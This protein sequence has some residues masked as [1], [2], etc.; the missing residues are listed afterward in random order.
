MY[1][2]LLLMLSILCISGMAVAQNVMTPTDGDYIYNTGA[3]AGSLTNPTAIDGIIQKWVHDPTQKPGRIPWTQSDFKSY[4][5]NNISFRLRF[6]NNYDPLQKYPLIVF[7]HGAGEAALISNSHNTSLISRENQDQLYWG[8]KLFRDTIN[9]PGSFNGFLLFPQ[10]LAGPNNVGTQWDQNT[11]D[12]VNNIL[13]TLEKYNGL[14]P[15]RVIAMGLSAG[16]LGCVKYAA[17]FP[18]RIAS[19]VTAGP[20]QLTDVLADIDGF[21][22]VPIYATIGGTDVNPYPITVITVRDQFAGKGGDFFLGFYPTLNHDTWETQWQQKN[23]YNRLLLTAYWNKASKAQP[24]VY[25]QASEFCSGQ[26]ISAKMGITAGFFAYEW[27]RDG[28]S[29][30]VTIPG[31][32]ANTY[33]ATQTGLYR[34]HFKRT[35]AY[36]WSDWTPNPVAITTKACAVTDTAFAEHFENSPVNNY[37]TFSGSGSGNSPYY[38]N[39][40][41][42]QNGFFVNGSEVFTQD[43][44]GRQGGKFMF[45]WTRNTNCAY[46]AGD[47][48]WRTYFPADVTPNTDYTLNFYMANQGTSMGAT[49]T[50]TVTAL[51]PKINN[52]ALS[53]VGVS[54]NG[55]GHL[56]WKKYSFNWNSGGNTSAEIAITNNVATGTGND[57]VLDEISLVKS[58]LVPMP[59]GALKNVDLW[60]KGSS[61]AS[62]DGGPVALWP[63]NDIN[64]NSLTQTLASSQPLYQ[65][66]GTDNIN[67][68]PVTAFLPQ[69]NKYMTVPGGFD[70]TAATTHTA[71]YAYM[72]LRTLATDQNATYLREGPTGNKLVM[73]QSTATVMKWNGGED[74]SNIIQ[75]PSGSIDLK[76]TIWS[77]SKNTVATPSGN[78]RDIRKNGLVLASSNTATTWNGSNNT[79]YLS[80]FQNTTNNFLGSYGG[81]IAEVIFILDSN[82]TANKQSN[83]ESYLALKYGTTLGSTA[84]PVN[85][86]AS[87]SSIYWTGS[88]TYQ[89]DVF[90]IGTDSANGLVQAI[91]NSINTG[92]G[93]GS[94]Q[95]A[96]GNLV[97]STP[98]ALL[99]KR[100]LVIGNDGVAPGQ[101]VIPAGGAAAIAVGSTRIN[102]E[103]K[104]SNKGLVGA[105][106]LSFDTTGLGNQQGGANVSEYGLMIDNDG[107]GNFNT[108]TLSFFNASSAS[109]KKIN[110]NGVTLN[111]NVVFT[112]LTFKLNAALP[113]VWLGFTAEAVNGNGLLKWKTSDEINVDRYVVEHS[114]N[115]VSYS[116]IGSV[117][118]NNNSGVN[119]YTLTDNGLSAGIHYYRIRRI[120]KDGKSEYS[121]IKSIK[122]SNSGGNV[123][124]MPNPVTGS[125]LVLAVSVQQSTKT[126]V[127]VMSVD[128]KVLLQQK[129]NLA[130]GNNLV[131][132]DVAYMPSGIY[133]LQVQ[134][135]GEFVT[136]KFIRQH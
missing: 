99:D 132:L 100:Y 25:N 91:S 33:T 71:V 62:F 49:P 77:F 80:A 113:A 35:A 57:F 114:F 12:P 65:T 67:F 136:K 27:Q 28:G 133:L 43:A 86:T 15:D 56:G 17:R 82:M 134:L 3:A 63:N 21:V 78:K 11:I 108:G 123:Q 64:G 85:Y 10:L 46:F 124:I 106:N 119:D 51:V 126:M 38:Q 73:A 111:N 13:D 59:G 37:I 60:A 45:N 50:S 68:N 31:A 87:D 66:A 53:P 1:Q 29:G 90:G 122:V 36:N 95:F 103:W 128:G 52:V 112:I 79:F 32:T 9:N 19:V 70:G 72:V 89:N 125:T 74:S 55:V 48:V 98:T 7:L 130:T 127:Q 34:V 14:D 107:D 47:Q 110:F 69:T 121:D 84:T 23:I 61:I 22:H 8:A 88:A 18:K 4:R 83:I 16:G 116:V 40:T 75:T 96:K 129:V 39:N 93:D 30:F 44:A 6:P 92:N 54:A 94:G 109:G 76:P 81:D 97:L 24:L 118:A 115:G 26:P 105:V 2:R 117:T 5:W 20:E 58:K 104:V 135:N 102:R 42:C 131:N 101:S 41:D 120:D